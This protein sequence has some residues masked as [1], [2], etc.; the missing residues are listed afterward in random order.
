MQQKNQQ[1]KKR[2]REKVIWGE[3]EILLTGELCKTLINSHLFFLGNNVILPPIQAECI[4]TSSNSQAI[5][6]TKNTFYQ[7]LSQLKEGAHQLMTQHM[8]LKSWL[9]Q[10]IAY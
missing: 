10:F 3:G 7:Y 4:K 1:K 2:A 8:P 5:I 9:D 6:R